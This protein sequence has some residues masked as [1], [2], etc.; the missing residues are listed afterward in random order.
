MLSALGLT[1][2]EWRRQMCKVGCVDEGLLVLNYD[3]QRVI[4]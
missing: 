3:L 2:H 1:T 4:R